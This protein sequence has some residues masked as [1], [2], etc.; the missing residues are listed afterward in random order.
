MEN[1]YQIYIN[2]LAEGATVSTPEEI[3]DKQL[4]AVVRTWKKSGAVAHY[5]LFGTETK[6]WQGTRKKFL[7][8]DIG[9]AKIML[10]CDEEFSGTSGR[11]ERLLNYWISAVV[12]DFDLQ[13]EENPVIILNR[14]KAL[15]RLQELNARRVTAGSEV[16][17]VVQVVHRVGYILNVGGYPAL[18]PLAY[19]DWDSSKSPTVGEGFNVK[20]LAVNT[21]GLVVSRRDLL[22]NPFHKMSAR[23]KK[24]SEVLATVTHTY[25]DQFKAEICPGVQISLTSPNHLLKTN[26]KV[27][28][29]VTGSNEREFF[30][31]VVGIVG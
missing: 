2:T 14:K 11:P 26:Q 21:R 12:E 28:A 29:H 18:L 13:D 15:K 17:G 27:R 19:Y 8:G 6:E 25:R 4:P 22:E 3:D 16:Y 9:S 1:T 7:I 30:G 24:N 5:R 10:P 20:I 23:I 31:V